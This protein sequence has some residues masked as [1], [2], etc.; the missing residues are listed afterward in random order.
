MSLLERI[1]AKRA[2]IIALGA[3]YGATNFRIFGSVLEGK[4]NPNDIDFL[5]DYTQP[6]DPERAG[7]GFYRFENLLGKML[8]HPVHLTQ[9]KLLK[10]HYAPYILPTAQA[11]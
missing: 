4:E 6:E 2:E 3:E 8:D 11:L 10:P 1:Q 7:L 9:A 5:I